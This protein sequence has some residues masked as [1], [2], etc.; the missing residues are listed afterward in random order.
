MYEKIN[1][2]KETSNQSSRVRIYLTSPL[3]AG[4]D[5]RLISKQSTIGLNTVVS[6]SKNGRLTKNPVYI[7]LYP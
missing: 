2:V 4:C 1:S 6:S 7:T 3:R 5:T